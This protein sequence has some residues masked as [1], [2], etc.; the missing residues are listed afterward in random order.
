LAF[1]L[2]FSETILAIEITTKKQEEHARIVS[3]NA[4]QNAKSEL[5]NVKI[6]NQLN[7]ES[8]RSAFLSIESESKSIMDTGRANAEAEANAQAMNLKAEAKVILSE[9]D[10]ES[11]KVVAVGQIERENLIYRITNDHAKAIDEMRI[12]TEEA[13]ANCESE[14]SDRVIA[15]IGKDTLVAMTNAGIENQTKMLESLGLKGYLLTDGQTPINLFS[16]AGGLLGN[17]MN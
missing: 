4:K 13:M 16:S 11:K 8:K 6:E 15:A 2:A 1:C 12:N 9:L 10:A 17:K 7:A 14:K 5:E 3:E